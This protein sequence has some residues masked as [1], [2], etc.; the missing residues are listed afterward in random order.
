ML[1][2]TVR[3]SIRRPTSAL[4]NK[5][6]TELPAPERNALLE[7]AEYIVRP[8]GTTVAAAG[9]PITMAFFPDTGVIAS[10]GEMAT[11][12][13]LAV[14]LVG[15][16]GVVGVGP[17]FSVT[18]F[19]RRLVA[20]LTSAGHQLPVGRFRDLF[21]Q[22]ATLRSLTLAHVGRVVDEIATLAACSRVHSHR[23]RLARWL[24]VLAEKSQQSSLPLTHDV[25]A[26]MVGG[27]RHAVTTALNHLREQGAV[28]PVRGRIDILDRS[29]LIA[30]ACE[31][32]RS[33]VATP[34]NFR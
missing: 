34:S 2:A 4:T 22:S 15:S 27:P 8:A 9:E 7:E 33:R 32:H 14:V 10:V 26:D 31:C 16:D 30:S 18:H 28:A 23:Q 12:H 5:I 11:G 25:V 29:V 21:N 17:L 1:L 3:H 24:L 20:I 19:P 13:H 6:L